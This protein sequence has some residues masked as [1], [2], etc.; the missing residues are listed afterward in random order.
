M[1][2][3]HIFWLY[4]DIIQWLRVRTA[5][6]ISQAEQLARIGEIDK[7][8]TEITKWIEEFHKEKFEIGLEEDPLLDQL[9]V[10]LT[11]CLNVLKGTNYNAYVENE[12]GVRMQAHFSQRCS[13]PS[14]KR[15]VYR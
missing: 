13:E 7:A 10:D 15:N 9:L 5:K 11:D 8:K 12:L 4:P 1:Q 6:V 3:S 14:L 2:Y